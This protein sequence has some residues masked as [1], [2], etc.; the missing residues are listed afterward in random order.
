M[1][2]EVIIGK[3]HAAEKAFQSSNFIVDGEAPSACHSALVKA[4]NVVPSLGRVVKPHLE[5]VDSSF[6]IV[7]RQFT[8]TTRIFRKIVCHRKERP[9]HS[10][11][12]RATLFMNTTWTEIDKEFLDS[13]VRFLSPSL[14]ESHINC[15][16]YP[17]YEH[18]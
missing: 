1:A 14:V 8:S 9:L 5:V 11:R 6:S 7:K 13:A 12:Q 4:Q 15:T 17:V 10:L 2:H 18:C 3:Q 16:L